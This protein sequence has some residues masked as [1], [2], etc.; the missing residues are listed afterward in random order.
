MYTSAGVAES[1][2]AVQCLKLFQQYPFHN[3]LHHQVSCRLQ[4]SREGWST[5]TVLGKTA[6]HTYAEVKHRKRNHAYLAC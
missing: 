4:E 2:A 5:A 3:L 1:G 6:G